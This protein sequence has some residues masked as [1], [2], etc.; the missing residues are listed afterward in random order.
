ML[1]SSGQ[2]DVGG[3]RDSV[4]DVR[5]ITA[6]VRNH[7]ER[8]HVNLRPRWKRPQTLIPPPDPDLKTEKERGTQTTEAP[9]LLVK[10]MTLYN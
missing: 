10:T 2:D 1:V 9:E 3:Q 5:R 4:P 7:K 8:G 6:L